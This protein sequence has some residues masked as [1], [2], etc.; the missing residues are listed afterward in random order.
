MESIPEIKE[1]IKEY[2][3]EASSKKIQFQRLIIIRDG[4]SDSQF[5]TIGAN[6]ITSIKEAINEVF[7]VLLN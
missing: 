7:N 2:L 4:I 3:N 1:M 6:E 5:N